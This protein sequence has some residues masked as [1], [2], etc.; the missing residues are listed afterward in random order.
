MTDGLNTEELYK[1]PVAELTREPDGGYDQTKPL[2]SKGRFSRV[3]YL[4]YSMVLSFVGIIFLAAVILLGHSLGGEGAKYIGRVGIPLGY[5]IMLPVSL[6][7]AI[8]RFH[9]MN[10][11]AWYVL[12]MFVPLLNMVVAFLLMLVPG[13]KGPNDYGPPPRP[14]GSGAAIVVFFLL[15]IFVSG[16][17]A[18]IAIPAYQDYV[19]A[20]QAAKA[21]RIEQR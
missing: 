15:V 18:A 17:L 16:I 12:T 21:H 3:Q 1:A 20:A 11:S 8:R 9:D 10:R 4:G 13:T 14:S 5:L 7:F 6:I 2:S 19:K